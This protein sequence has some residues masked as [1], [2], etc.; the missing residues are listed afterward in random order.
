MIPAL[1][2]RAE[3]A[4][5]AAHCEEAIGL[6]EQV[7][8]Q[9]PGNYNLYYTLG[10]CVS[11]GCRQHALASSEMAAIY[12]RQA[13]QLLG[14]AGGA[15]RAAILDALGNALARTT[16]DGKAEALRAAI[17]HQGEAA[18]IYEAHGEE[19]DWAR[20]QFNLGNS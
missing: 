16:G 17:A 7:V 2:E 14:P 5:A 11:G 15:A 3:E 13:L 6:L 10:L 20:V 8:W 19:D 18:G 1:V 9:Q 4:C 12:L